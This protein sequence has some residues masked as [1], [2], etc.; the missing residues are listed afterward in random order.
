MK[1][2]T[3]IKRKGRQAISKGRE[4]ICSHVI[5]WWLEGKGLKLSDMDIEQIK[6]SLIENYTT[7]ELNA[8]SPNG[9]ITNGWWSVQW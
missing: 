1:T 3:T 6:N 4:K 9:N 5:E 8:I 2:A 7:G